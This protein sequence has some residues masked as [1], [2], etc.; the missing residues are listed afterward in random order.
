MQSLETESKNT[1]AETTAPPEN[2]ASSEF[3]AI[4]AL[5]IEAADPLNT[6]SSETAFIV[7]SKDA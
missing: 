6:E 1:I 4:K 3:D 7:A 2:V 5:I